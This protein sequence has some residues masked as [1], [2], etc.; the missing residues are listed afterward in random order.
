[1]EAIFDARKKRS[2]I[3]YPSCFFLIHDE[4]CC[5]TFCL[6]E[7][8]QLRTAFHQ[9]WNVTQFPKVQTREPVPGSSGPRSTV[10]S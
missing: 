8:N 3:F 7:Q 1:M 9:V 6:L 2:L 5:R 4:I 10:S